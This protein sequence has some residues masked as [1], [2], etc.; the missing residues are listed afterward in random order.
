MTSDKR[1]EQ[2]TKRESFL[3]S[4]LAFYGAYH[5]DRYNRIVHLVFVPTLVWTAAVMLATLVRGAELW[6]LLAYSSFYVAMDLLAGVSWAFC[7]GYPCFWM[8]ERL[9]RLTSHAWKW[10]LALH[11]LSWIVQVVVG[12]GM[13]EKRKPALVDSF[14][15]SLALAPL[16]VWMEVLFALGY[17]PGLEQEVSELVRERI[18]A[19]DAAKKK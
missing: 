12:H 5:N 13:Y 7:V 10:A 2:T 1:K 18:A 8:T 3:T 4:Q 9:F 15:Q 11:V 16:F 19:M 14:F 6:L 17:K